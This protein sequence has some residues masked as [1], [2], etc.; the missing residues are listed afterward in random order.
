MMALAPYVASNKVYGVD[1][2]QGLQHES[3][4]VSENKFPMEEH[5]ATLD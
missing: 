4:E 2:P 5:E 3:T 1:L